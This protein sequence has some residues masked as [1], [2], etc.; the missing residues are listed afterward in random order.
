[1]QNSRDSSVWRSL[2]V[3]FGD[4]VAFGVGMKLTQGA[5]RAADAPS[6]PD[7][8]PL[9]DRLERIE[10]RLALVE[11]AP[12]QLGPPSPP[13]DQKVLETVVNAV[14]A[15][16]K[17]HAGQVERRLADLEAKIAIELASLRQQDHSDASAAQSRLEEIHSRLQEQVT[18]V[19]NSVEDDLGQ[20]AEAVGLMVEE[21]TAAAVT[22]Q[23]AP[24][25]QQMRKEIAETAANA[26]EGNLAPLRAQVTG[27]EREIADLRQRMADGERTVLDALLAVGEVCS[28]A[29]ERL[30]RRAPAPPDSAAPP[31]VGAPS[32]EVESGEGPAGDPG[33][34][35]RLAA[36]EAREAAEPKGQSRPWRV[37]LVSSFMLATTGLLLLHYL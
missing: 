4:G 5:G 21:R 8:S 29:A 9:A 20:F 30:G 18:A 26:I 15:R 3:A 1:M 2:A 28:K 24:L 35:V 17:E 11:Q 22:A 31:D 13:F 37:P 33:G 34:P 7:T 12:A 32:P 16:L 19:R 23:V 27:K 10:R 6:Q 25:E 14:D 36:V